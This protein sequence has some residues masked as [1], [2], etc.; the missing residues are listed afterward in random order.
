MCNK[1][2]QVLQGMGGLETADGLLLEKD[3]QKEE[4]GGVL[5]GN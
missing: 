4:D 5:Q 2:R 1:A 3:Q